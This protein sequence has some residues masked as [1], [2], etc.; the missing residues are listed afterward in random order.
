MHGRSY[1]LNRSM[2]WWKGLERSLLDPAAYFVNIMFEAF[3]MAQGELWRVLV[4]FDY[5][6][7][8]IVE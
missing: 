7:L 5:G 6:S 3:D 1:G 2:G 4:D 8:S